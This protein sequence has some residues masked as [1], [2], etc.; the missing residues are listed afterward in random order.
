MRPLQQ[1]ELVHFPRLAFV[2]QAQELPQDMLCQMD[3]FSK[4]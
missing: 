2:V 3:L 1:W 4:N